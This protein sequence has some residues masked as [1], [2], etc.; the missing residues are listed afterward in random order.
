MKNRYVFLDWLKITFNSGIKLIFLKMSVKCS[1][2]EMSCI[3]KYTLL[4]KL[5]NLKD[6]LITEMMLI[7]CASL[8][9]DV[10]NNEQWY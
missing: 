10:H 5:M 2:N 3:M 1:L 4:S 7:Y 6:Q 8:N 9:M